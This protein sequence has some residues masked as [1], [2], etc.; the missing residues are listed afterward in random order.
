MKINGIFEG[1]INVLVERGNT[2][3]QG[4]SVGTIGFVD[5]NNCI[6]A[7]SEIVD[8]GLSGLPYRKLLSRLVKRKNISLLE[9]INQLPDNAVLISTEPGQTGII[10]GT[11]GINIFNLPIVRI[12]VKNKK[13]VGV[14]VLYPEKDFFRLATQSEKA[15]LDSLMALNMEDEREALRLSTEIK[16]KF[17]RI[18]EE[19]PIVKGNIN[20]IPAKISNDIW[21][22]PEYRVKRI[23]RDFAEDL[24]AKS[25][26]IEQG[27]EVAALGIINDDGVIEQAGEI[28]IGG[29]GYVPSRLLASSYCDIDDISLREAYTNII[30]K[31]TVI[32]HTHPGGT[33][34]MHINDAMAGPGTW[35]RPIIAI[36]HNENGEI[37][38][39]TVIEKSSKL[40]GLADENE[41]LEGKFFRAE[42]PEEELKI[43]KRR[44]GL[45]QEFTDLCNEIII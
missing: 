19:L 21:E 17:L 20:D 7:Y 12:G 2:L 14:G 29:M 43:R 16:L 34:V 15:E 9:L 8:G 27:R 24:V 6:S 23:S 32:V 1:I 38:G 41:I 4:R 28:V 37:K 22:I 13:L 31:S 3:G 36:G 39:A 30:P 45:A 42:T 11:G 35:G 33:G 10:V 40:F 26:S 44:Y 5:S 25:N 18:S